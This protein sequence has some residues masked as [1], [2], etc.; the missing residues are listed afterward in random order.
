[1]Y[2]SEVWALVA[3]KHHPPL[4]CSRFQHFIEGE[5]RAGLRAA[6]DACLAAA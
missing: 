4:L 5:V 6:S 3:G 2:R 1:M